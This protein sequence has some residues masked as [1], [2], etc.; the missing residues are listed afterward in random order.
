MT[1]DEISK[2]IAR[3]VEHAPEWLRQDLASK[4]LAARGRA[5]E[6]LSAMIAAALKA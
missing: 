4:D 5:E 6:T 2:R 3:V 1:S